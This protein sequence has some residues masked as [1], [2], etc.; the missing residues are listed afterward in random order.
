MQY[1]KHFSHICRMLKS[2]VSFS[3]QGYIS[4]ME[5]E[6]MNNTGDP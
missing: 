3:S 5:N 4:D 1:E 6:L 2:K